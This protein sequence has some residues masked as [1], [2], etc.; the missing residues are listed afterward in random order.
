[1]RTLTAFF[2]LL[3]ACGGDTPLA[4]D[5]LSVE[6]TVESVT[7]SL[8]PSG[9]GDVITL[10]GRNLP[11]DAEL[12]LDGAPAPGAAWRSP[13][14]MTFV[15]PRLT[16]GV[17]ELLLRA[18]GRVLWSSQTLR[19]HASEIQ[20]AEEPLPWASVGGSFT[21]RHA[22][23]WRV[24]DVTGSAFDEVV[25]WRPTGFAESGGPIGDTV[26]LDGRSE[27]ARHPGSPPP[28]G[29]VDVD[30]D[31]KADLVD[32]KGARTGGGYRP[33]V[34]DEA[35]IGFA[36][37]LRTGSG[38]SQSLLF[39][40]AADGTRL[41]RVE[42]D[43]TTVVRELPF[44]WT[45][46]RRSPNLAA[47]LDFDG[48]G[49]DDLAYAAE[50]RVV[51][52]RGPAFTE[53][54]T[55]PGAYAMVMEQHFDPDD[56]G[57]DE[58]VVASRVGLA[59]VE[60][61]GPDVV[62]HDYGNVCGLGGAIRGFA[63]GGEADRLAVQCHDQIL[64]LGKSTAPDVEG[65]VTLRRLPHPTSTFTVSG[66]GQTISFDTAEQ[67]LP[68]FARLE[69]GARAAM[70]LLDRA[71]DQSFTGGLAAWYDN[72]F[73]GLPNT[74]DY[75]SGLPTFPDGAVVPSWNAVRAKRVGERLVRVTL[76]GHVVARGAND[77]GPLTAS[78][79]FVDG[80]RV[81]A[82]V[83]CDLDHDGT[84][85]LA[86][87]AQGRLATSKLIAVFLTAEGV[88]VGPTADFE[89]TTNDMYP[90][91]DMQAQRADFDGDGRDEVWVTLSP[92]SDESRRDAR[93]T[94]GPDGWIETALTVPKFPVPRLG[95]PPRR[96]LDVD[97]DGDGD[98]V[99]AAGR[100][101]FYGMLDGTTVTWREVS[102]DWVTVGLEGLKVDGDAIWLTVREDFS[103]EP[104]RLVRGHFDGGALVVDSG[105]AE[106]ISAT[107]RFLDF[108][109]VDGDG[110]AD[111]VEGRR[112]VRALPGG[113]LEASV[114]TA[115]SHP[116][117]Y[118][119][120]LDLDGDGLVDLAALTPDGELVWARNRSQ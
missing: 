69:E 4:D 36:A 114:A 82:T 109:D 83:P 25:F 80:D 1:M 67:V 62:A 87:L 85:D 110:E 86:V 21:D 42:A 12:L 77:A 49:A 57:R 19:T 108:A 31:G 107:G 60:L 116:D 9:G 32:G 3:A 76:D 115:V 65:I 61:D 72:D 50:D 93:L 43:S 41:A 13:T 89:A 51:V 118:E 112:V 55:A 33:L 64:V 40:Q 54:W 39:V 45:T 20:F 17:H 88:R 91:M 71:S 52:L 103:V 11:E 38:A 74:P 18:R 92:S 105:R 10:T 30:G 59:V 111:W 58:L 66:T 26:I 27:V 63:P 100:S 14:R 48:D 117:V 24:G 106:R 34:G 73:T 6:V 37:E 47:V 94:L 104:L 84:E 15:A 68:R 70:I 99:A 120:V 29:L 96:V 28:V 81:I 16:R 23:V 56:D 97:G 8:I 22:V 2:L 90:T 7:P 113:D 78:L 102:Y 101:L 46:Q 119:G 5:S 44:P 79:P 35:A 98:I 75:V 95:L 53:L